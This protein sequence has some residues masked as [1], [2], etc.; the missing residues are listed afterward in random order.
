MASP[1]KTKTNKSSHNKTSS[2]KNKAGS[3][4]KHETKSKKATSKKVGYKEHV[5]HEHHK[6]NKREV[7]EESQNKIIAIVIVIILAIGILAFAGYETYVYLNNNSNGKVNGSSTNLNKGTNNTVVNQNTGS[8]AL[9]LVVIEDPNCSICNI[10]G[11]YNA[12][13]TKLLPGL[14]LERIPY[15]SKKGEQFVQKL[16]I[17]RVP[18][19]LFNNEITKTKLWSD[20]RFVSYLKNITINNQKYYMLDQRT[21][22]SLGMPVS[23]IGVK[24]QILNGTPV[25]GNPNA[26]IT[27][28]E[29]TDFQC[30][31]CALAAGGRT[32]PGYN[33][34]V[35]NIIKNYVDTGKAKLVVYNFPLDQIHPH[36]RDAAN[37]IMCAN[38]IIYFTKTKINGLLMKANL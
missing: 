16:G 36:A 25:I 31:F 22:A 34:P 38:T 2:K 28:Y 11:F 20:P 35:P 5:K 13:K 29:F 8:N 37:A 17:N 23:L 27:I 30:P 6:E 32:Q 21:A 26:P 18:V 19:F 10:S 15:N 4:T 7:K 1:K 3:A 24:L 12:L 33:P 9:K 14:Q